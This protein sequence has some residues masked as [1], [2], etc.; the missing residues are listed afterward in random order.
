M[1][2]NNNNQSDE[3]NQNIKE[4]D[5]NDP[6]LPKNQL[7]TL[8]MSLLDLLNNNQI[9]LT[10]KCKNNL[11]IFLEHTLDWTNNSCKGFSPKSGVFTQK[12]N[13]INAM[14][15]EYQQR[16][17]NLYNAPGINVNE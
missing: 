4:D 8:C 11:K 10:A 9:D 12:I 14:C 15:N 7:L 2:E 3:Y 1:S 13:T 5:P 6:D 16:T 17:F